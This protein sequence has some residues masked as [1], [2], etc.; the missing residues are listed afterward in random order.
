MKK[1]QSAGRVLLAFF[2]GFLMLSGGGFKAQAALNPANFTDDL[3]QLV[4]D[5]NLLL[6]SM[7]SVT[8]KSLTMTSQLATLENSTQIYL[9]SVGDVYKMVSASKDNTTMSL[10]NEMLVPL[11]TLSTITASLTQSLGGLAGQ[12]AVLSSF[13]SL[14]TLESSLTSML[15]LS[16]DIGVMADRILEMSDQILIMADNI[17]IM[18]DRILATQIIQGDNLQVIVDASLATQK[19]ILMMFSMFL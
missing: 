13:T 3:N 18:A 1:Q 15:R 2:F 19:N 4:L 9:N 7:E 14:S 12:I 5:G 10:T 17:G 16:D 6:A 11:Q 8:L